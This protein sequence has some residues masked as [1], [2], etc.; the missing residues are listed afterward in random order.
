MIDNI[1]NFIFNH[2]PL[3]YL[4]QSLWRDE[5]FSYFMAKPPIGEI[6]FNSAQDFNPPLYYIFLHLWMQVV[7]KSDMGLRLLSFVFFAAAVY[8]TY[9]LATAVFNRRFALFTTALM[10]F[11]PM[12]LYYA[13]EL[14]MYA[15][16]VFFVVASLYSFV[17]KRW[18]LYTLTTALGLYTHSFFIL[19][20]LCLLLYTV[21]KHRNRKKIVELTRP[22]IFFLPW[23]PVVATQFS[24]SRQS[25]LYPVDLQSI[26]SSLGNLFTG[27]EGTPDGLWSA[28]AILSAIIGLFLIR[29]LWYRKTDAKIYIT[30]IVLPLVLIMG[31][32]VLRRPLF[33][34]RYMIFVTV[35]E[36][37][38]VCLAIASIRS[39]MVRKATA[40]AWLLFCLG[41]NV[42]AVQ[43]H[44]KTDFKTT[45]AEINSRAKPSDYVY[46]QTPIGYLES[47]YYYR[48]P[49]QVFIY[50]PDNIP[51]PYYIGVTVLFP[52]VT[53]AAFPSAPSTT[54]LVADDA[55]YEVIL[56]Q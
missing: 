15:L 18:K 33:V 5:V 2:T 43:F 20:P 13:F 3:F 49:E 24:N 21:L 52:D 54:Y 6:I 14:R 8:M 39:A 41:L 34:N 17:T 4:T 46:T 32:S 51:V 23:I 1:S 48:T 10:F 44:R 38:G 22:F 19:L 11:N 45:F 47:A 9:M 7:G 53:R 12:L 29:A 28:T 35:L 26:R 36:V 40:A 37:I 16:Y 55:S 27:Y 25:W 31:Y 56:Q 30:A 42:F 50:N